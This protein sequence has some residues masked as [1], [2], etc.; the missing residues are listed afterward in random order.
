MTTHFQVDL[1]VLFGVI[2]YGAIP[3]KRLTRQVER[4]RTYYSCTVRLMLLEWSVLIR[5]Y[6]IRGN[7]SGISTSYCPLSPLCIFRITLEN[8][9]PKCL[10]I[11][12]RGLT[13]ML[14]D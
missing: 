6:N 8:S 7:R 14:Q 11:V 1:N 4:V 5:S 12:P 9:L 13:L 3:S 2:A 10:R